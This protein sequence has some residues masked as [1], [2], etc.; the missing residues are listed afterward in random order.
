MELS[1]SGTP[2]ETKDLRWD[3]ALNM[4]G[5][6]GRLEGL[7][8]GMDIMYV[9]DV[10]YAGAKAASFSGGNFM[11]I[12]GGKWQRNDNGE[13]ILDKNGMP[14]Y[15]TDVAVGN[16]EPKFTGGLNNTLTWKNLTFNML[17]EF[18]VGGDVINGTKY[19]MDIAGVSEESGKW[20]NEPLTIK[21]VDADGNPVSHTWEAGK[22]YEYSGAMT[23]GY[24]II[25][26]FYTGYYTK[27]TSNYITK[28]NS[29]RLRSVSVS[30][31][32]PKKWLREKIGFVKRASVSVAATNLLLFTN[33]DGD[34]EA[35]A[36]GAG[37]GGS[38]SVGF[39]YCGVPATSTMS[40]GLNLTF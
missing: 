38:S 22:A 28:V 15:V 34:P 31:E 9:T 40:F 16:R 1:I 30:Y 12:S 17:W 2:I 27:E 21:G 3:V 33:Y 14:T 39:D 19:A 8:E 36:A 10:Q 24:N 32:L 11:G 26:D 20:R 37:V 5:N 18:R 7:P 23:S 4:A 25:K 35:A 29:L 6:R 13:L